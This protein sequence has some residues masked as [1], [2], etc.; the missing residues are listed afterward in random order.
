MY[1]RRRKNP[2][3]GLIQLL[4]AVAVAW[5][6]VTEGWPWLRERLDRTSG[7]PP[8]RPSALSDTA[9]SEAGRCLDRAEDASSILA[10]ALRSFR[11][12]P[13]DQVAWGSASLEIAGALGNADAACACPHPACR[14]AAAAVGVLRE[15]HTMADDMIRGDPKAVGNLGRLRGRAYDHLDEARE[16]FRSELPEPLDDEDF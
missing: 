12:P 15:M 10:G 4:L 3:V 13:H 6:A 8:D 14:E 9:R 11:N 16:L 5:F 7:A 2:I 1:Y